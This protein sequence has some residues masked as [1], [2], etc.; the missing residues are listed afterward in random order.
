MHKI[1][2]MGLCVGAAFMMNISLAFGM[3][4]EEDK[5]SVTVPSKLNKS[6]QTLSAVDFEG[7]ISKD[8]RHLIVKQA[9]YEQCLENKSPVNLALVCKEWRGIIVDDMQVGQPSWKAWYGV[10]SH[11]DIYERFLKGVLVYRPNEGSDV[12]KIELPIAALTNPLGSPFDLSKCGNTGQYLSIATGYRKGKKAENDRKVEIWLAPR[13]L[14]EKELQGKASH[15]A[16]I[17]SA[18]DVQKAPIGLFFNRGEWDN[19][20]DYDYLTSLDWDSITSENLYKKW[21]A[22]RATRH[23]YT[24]R[25]TIPRGLRGSVGAHVRALVSCFIYELKKD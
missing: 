4:K 13:F 18:W 3:E 5:S 12:G 10:V 1:V 20:E 16:P 25:T 6:P 9:S 11:E 19:L 2:K 23:H 7:H 22:R 17:M 24:D 14:I 15:F 8:V 21:H